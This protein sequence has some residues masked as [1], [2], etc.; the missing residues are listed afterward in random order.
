MIMIFK[1]YY[2]FS[3]RNASLDV[4]I[5]SQLPT[6]P[7]P[8]SGLLAVTISLSKGRSEISEYFLPG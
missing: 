4:A 3:T 5:S 8:R 6:V 2:V 7:S 1:H